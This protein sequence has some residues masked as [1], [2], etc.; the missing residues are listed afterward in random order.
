MKY[1]NAMNEMRTAMRMM[2][3]MYAELENGDALENKVW[4]DLGRTIIKAK[5]EYESANKRSKGE[6][7][8]DI[9]EVISIHYD[10][11]DVIVEFDS[12]YEIQS[13]VDR[14]FSYISDFL[15][16]CYDSSIDP[17]DFSGWSTDHIYVNCELTMVSDT[18]DVVDKF[19]EDYDLEDMIGFFE[20]HYC[21]YNEMDELTEL[22]KEYKECK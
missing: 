7:L 12:D 8:N 6:I 13:D 18:G 17:M 11:Y 20:E 15:N 9:N 14:T 5:N 3:Q 19:F 16:A 2:E 10:W 21:D 22:I 4:K 1:N